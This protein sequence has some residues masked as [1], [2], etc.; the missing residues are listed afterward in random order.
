MI[1]TSLVPRTS[2]APV[3]YTRLQYAR[4]AGR[5]PGESYHVIHGTGV[6]S[7][8]AISIAMLGRQTDHAFCTS[9]R[10]KTS[11]Q[12]TIKCRKH[13]QARRSSSK[14]LQNYMCE[15]SAVT[16]KAN[17]AKSSYFWICNACSGTILK[18]L[19]FGLGYVLEAGLVFRLELVLFL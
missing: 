15:I 11:T 10:D 3:F 7:R 4:N 2:P 17:V 12:N 19:C 9:Y 6:T 14:G 18:R 8:H 5:R 1:P 13:I 16:K